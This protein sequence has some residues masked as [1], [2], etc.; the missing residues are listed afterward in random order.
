MNIHER[1]VGGHKPVD[2]DGL[3][4]FLK[5]FINPRSESTKNSKGDEGKD[6]TLVG[7][8]PTIAGFP[9]FN[10]QT[11]TLPNQPT[12]NCAESLPAS[13]LATNFAQTHPLPP[14][15]NSFTTTIG[16]MDYYIPELYNLEQTEVEISSNFRIARWLAE[17]FPET[18]DE[19]VEQQEDQFEL[20]C[21]KHKDYGPTNL[22]QG[23]VP[24]S[25]EGIL[26]RMK[27]K[28]NRVHKLNN[29]NGKPENESLIDSLNDISNYANIAIIFLK[30][31]WGL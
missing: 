24:E 15:P 25:V 4:E 28:L 12:E 21:K 5:D 13:D 3:V 31:K 1:K 22:V 2:L 26:I 8:I 18:Y 14:Q 6:Y 20:F 23:S 10:F 16:S 29:E 7:D 27:D 17:T 11:D 30:G 9:Y 19:F